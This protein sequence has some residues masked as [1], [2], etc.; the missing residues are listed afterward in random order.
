MVLMRN[1]FKCPPDLLEAQVMSSFG[2]LLQDVY[3]DQFTYIVK[4]N[5][6]A[7]QIHVFTWCNITNR[8]W[9]T[10]AFHCPDSIISNV[11]E[12]IIS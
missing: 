6:F 8:T 10:T 2:N 3:P 9:S 12:I 7:E 1:C 4:A 5:L 11:R